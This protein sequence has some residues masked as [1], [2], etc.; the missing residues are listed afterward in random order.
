MPWRA[1]KL[2]QKI[3]GPKRYIIMRGLGYNEEW[4]DSWTGP[5]YN[6]SKKR[7][8]NGENITLASLNL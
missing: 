5:K 8:Y 1:K 6:K 2:P 3:N 7:F 4:P